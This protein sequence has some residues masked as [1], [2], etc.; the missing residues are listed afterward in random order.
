VDLDATYAVTE[1]VVLSDWFSKRPKKITV[2][3]ATNNQIGQSIFPTYNNMLC[4]ENGDEMCDW[5]DQAT[6]LMRVYFDQPIMASQLVV[7]V[8][9]LLQP[10]G[11][12]L[13]EGV[14]VHGDPA[15]RSRISDVVLAKEDQHLLVQWT[16]D[17]T[18]PNARL[19]VQLLDLEEVP[20]EPQPEITVIN[21][22][23][24]V[25]FGAMAKS[26]TFRARVRGALENGIRGTWSDLSNA[27]TYLPRQ[28]PLLKELQITN[29]QIAPPENVV[30]GQD[31]LP[32]RITIPLDGLF[33]VSEVV[34]VSD[35]WAKRPREIAVFDETGRPPFFADPR[36]E[37]GA[38]PHPGGDC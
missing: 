26:G 37:C 21:N 25:D 30:E 8:D 7:E 22:K 5:P 9:G 27:I 10:D 20:L 12:A 38:R 34:V 19:E 2:F 33:K 35:W 28:E 18:D 31:T 24:Q 36:P 4:G 11:V 16:N 13:L 15:I 23:A 1:V 6:S 29:P 17:V 32:Y 14:R 3:D